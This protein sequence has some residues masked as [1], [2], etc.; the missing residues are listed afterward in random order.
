M[1]HDVYLAKVKPTAEVSEEWDYEEIV[2]TIPAEEAFQP[3][4]GLGL[5]DA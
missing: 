3:V 4:D 1:V 5:L 2:T